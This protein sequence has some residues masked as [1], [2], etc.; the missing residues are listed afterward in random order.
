MESFTQSVM[1][2]GA[3]K[4]WHH[5]DC[6]FHVYMSDVCYAPKNYQFES[7]NAYSFAK[8]CCESV[9]TSH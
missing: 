9:G 8:A 7:K 3:L 1:L 2:V 5:L 4:W 6:I